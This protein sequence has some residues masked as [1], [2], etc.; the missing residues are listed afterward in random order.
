M[1]V[2]ARKEGAE[3]KLWL[4]PDVRTAYSKGMDARTV[5]WIVSVVEAHRAVIQ[6]AWHEHF[7]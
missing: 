4:H 1:H 7:S 3:A 5:R 6:A 2:H